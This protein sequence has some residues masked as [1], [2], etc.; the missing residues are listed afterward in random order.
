MSTV[1]KETAIKL[2]E[3]WRDKQ[4]DDFY[5]IKR[6]TPL[7]T[8]PKDWWEFTDYYMEIHLP[9]AQEI[10]DEL[11]CKIGDYNL[12]IVFECWQR[13]A[14]TSYNHRETNNK[15]EDHFCRDAYLTSSLAK[16]RIRCKD[17]WHIKD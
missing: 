13:K 17:N 3:A 12:S 10:L 4:C 15:L 5:D 9:H 6:K 16:L 8:Q 2:K 1:S 7:V 14:V 11:P